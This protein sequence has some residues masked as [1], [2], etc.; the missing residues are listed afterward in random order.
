MPMLS[1]W[2]QWKQRNAAII[3]SSAQSLGGKNERIILK[4]LPNSTSSNPSDCLAISQS[5]AFV[6][7]VALNWPQTQLLPTWPREA[8]LPRKETGMLSN[9]QWGPC[10]E[11]ASSMAGQYL[12][13][14]SERH[15][16]IYLAVVICG[17]YSDDIQCCSIWKWDTMNA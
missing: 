3:S 2:I 12:L 10:N 1:M 17:A 7:P 4:K 6:H 9:L 16:S 11:A 14:G 5:N 8:R 13:T 15:I